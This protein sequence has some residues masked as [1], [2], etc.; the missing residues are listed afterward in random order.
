MPAIQ[1]TRS[2][3]VA[4]FVL[5]TLGQASRTAPAARLLSPDSCQIQ[6]LL[7]AFLVTALL[8]KTTKRRDGTVLNLCAAMALWAL[9]A[10]LL[11]YAGHFPVGEYEPHEPHFPIC[12]AQAVLVYMGIC[13]SSESSR[14]RR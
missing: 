1:A 8:V 14:A 4:F 3:L 11:L 5:S 9:G 6:I 13:E 7:L 12:L 2:Q 10:N